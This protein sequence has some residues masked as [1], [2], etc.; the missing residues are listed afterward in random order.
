MRLHEFDGKNQK[1]NAIISLLNLIR[2]KAD[3]QGVAAILT[4]ENFENLLANV[5]HGVTLDELESLRD[6]PAIG[7]LIVDMDE[8]SVTI[9][10]EHSPTPEPEFDDM[11]VDFD[12]EG[13]D[14]D[15]DLDL[16]E[17]TDEPFGADTNDDEDEDLGSMDNPEDTVKGMADRASKRRN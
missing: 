4:I 12:D 16:D 2:T 10:S 3:Q 6:N 1:L 11:D 9:A 15:V 8:N 5:G 13:D 17:P 14:F 7:N